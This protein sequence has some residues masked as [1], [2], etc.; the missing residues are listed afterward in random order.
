MVSDGSYKLP[1]ATGA[2]I[3][4]SELHM[5]ANHLTGSTR[6][7]GPPSQQD[8][9]RAELFG[10]LAGMIRIQKLIKRWQLQDTQLSLRVG[11]DN[12]N[13][14]S[15]CFDKRTH[16]FITSRCDHFDVILAFRATVP[17]NVTIIPIW[18]KGHQDDILA[19]AQL[20]PLSRLNVRMDD[21]C[22]ELRRRI[23]TGTQLH[24]WTALLPGWHWL[25]EV[26]GH[27]LTKKVRHNIESSISA[28]RMSTYLDHKNRLQPHQ[29]QQICWDS[30]G[31][32][33]KSQ[34]TGYKRFITKHSAGVCGVNIWR[35]RWRDRDDDACPR[36]G[37]PENSRHVY[38][39]SDPAVKAI[40]TLE[41]SLLE[42]WLEDHQT[43]PSITSD[44]LFN[45][46]KMSLN[47]PIRLRSAL[48]QT[49]SE[50]GW[51]N[52]FEGLI[53][54]Q[55]EQAQ[56]TYLNIHATLHRRRRR[57]A[58]LWTRKLFL[59]LWSI[60]HTFWT[61]RNEAEHTEDFHR[62]LHSF[63]EKIQEELD[64]GFN[65]IPDNRYQYMYSQR[66]IDNVFESTN[67]NYKRSWLRNLHALR[68]RQQRPRRPRAR[69]RNRTQR[70]IPAFFQQTA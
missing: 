16:P 10:L 31:K 63:N 54:Q 5:D 24:S 33:I 25:L 56:Q 35:H 20:D 27:L 36:C 68:M 45:L 29:F 40:W 55:W 51:Q 7:T 12:M 69:L 15:F 22:K 44:I 18:V 14:L 17:D 67:L 53:H 62:A 52:F 42:Q 3:F 57:S 58:K 66:E 26:K 47:E 21:L 60:H 1:F 4:T 38:L 48:E 34:P 37:Q 32:A 49:Q 9:Y 30:I 41:L 64:Q 39:C 46:T 2:Y 13:A 28:T 6:T 43:C 61:S 70:L 11:C 23:E 65:D 59:K 50:I 8:S 19:K